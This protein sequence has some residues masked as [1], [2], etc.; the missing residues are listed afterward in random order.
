MLQWSRDSKDLVREVAG[1]RYNMC[2]GLKEG[3]LLVRF[4]VK[5]STITQSTVYGI[6]R[7]TPFVSFHR[8]LPL[9][10]RVEYLA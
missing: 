3:S 10:H 5:Y 2:G 4:E 7:R 8:C 9:F 1:G 6:I